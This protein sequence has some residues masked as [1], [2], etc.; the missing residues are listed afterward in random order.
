MPFAK[1]KYGQKVGIRFH[2]V[3]LGGAAFSSSSSFGRFFLNVLS[4]VAELERSMIAERTKTAL[5]F[6]RSRLEAYSA[7]PYGYRRVQDHLE[8]GPREL[9][10]VAK[11]RSDRS[12]G[13]SFQAIATALNASGIPTKNGGRNWF[14]STVRYI[15]MN[16]LYSSVAASV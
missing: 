11:I 6:K 16:D 9:A 10:V 8:A 7:T 2:V 4:G 5:A 14:P 12:S 3:D 13:M 15:V 1:R